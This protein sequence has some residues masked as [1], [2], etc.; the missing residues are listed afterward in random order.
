[1]V[2]LEAVEGRKN[3]IS[4]LVW[5]FIWLTVTVVALFLQPDASG[6]GTHM[7]LGLPPCPSM[8]SFGKPCPGCG[9]TT[10]FVAFIHGQWCTTFAAHPLGPLLYAVL[11]VVGL[12][13]L[14]GWL[15]SK[16]VQADYRWTNIALIALFVGFFDFGV[17]RFFLSP[18]EDTSILALK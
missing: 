12:G 17:T 5:F 4:H 2:R 15:R 8:L 13:G 7:Q 3:L 1:M 14:T 10:S 16:R 18:P 11:T 6:H 9:L